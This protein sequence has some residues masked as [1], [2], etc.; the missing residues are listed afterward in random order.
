MPDDLA[1]DTP[2]PVLRLGNTGGTRIAAAGSVLDLP[3]LASGPRG[4]AFGGS[5]GA[6]GAAI[7]QGTGSPLLTT[8]R[9][10]I[11]AADTAGAGTVDAEPGSRGTA[12]IASL[13]AL[14]ALLTAL[15]AVRLALRSRRG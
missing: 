13:A 3:P 14:A 15:G 4:S 10:H 8:D 7:L 12:A 11:E 9:D 2:A 1:I 6:P 5:L